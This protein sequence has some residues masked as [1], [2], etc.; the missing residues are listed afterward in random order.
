MSRI[1]NYA[2]AD[3]RGGDRYESVNEILAVPRYK[4]ADL[5]RNTIPK[6]DQKQIDNWLRFDYLDLDSQCVVGGARDF[7]RMAAI[8]RE[9][10]NLGPG[11]RYTGGDI[12]KVMILQAIG[13]MGLPYS[14]GAEIIRAALERA[15]S[16]ILSPDGDG[17]HGVIVVIPDGAGNYKPYTANRG[18]ILDHIETEWFAVIDIDQ[19][20]KR[21]FASPRGRQ[22]EAMPRDREHD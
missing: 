12:L 20:I 18:E 21:F 6:I 16:M 11:R 7:R 4:R 9:N 3:N 5:V 1:I 13:Q 17:R 10:E 2:P 15:A 8:T 19:I 22:T 14:L